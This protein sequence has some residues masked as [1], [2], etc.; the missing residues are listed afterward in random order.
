MSYLTEYC[1]REAA[2]RSLHLVIDDAPGVRNHVVVVPGKGV[3]ASPGCPKAVAYYLHLLLLLL[4]LF[5]QLLLDVICC[6]RR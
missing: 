4:P 2:T 6:Q 1:T 3:V 5:G